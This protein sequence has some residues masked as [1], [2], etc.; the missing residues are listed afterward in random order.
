[1]RRLLLA[2]GLVALATAARAGGRVETAQ[3][4]VPFDGRPRAIQVRTPAASAD[5]ANL[6]VV[7]DGPQ[8]LD[9]IPL[10]AMLD[11]LEA[12]GRIPPTVAVLIDDGTGTVRIAD[13]GNRRAFADWVCDRLVPWVR[14]RYRVSSDPHRV[15]AYGSSAGGLAAAFIAFERPDVVGNALSQSG[16]FWRNAEAKGSPPWEWLTGAVAAAPR[17]DVRFVIDVGEKETTG[18]L[19]GTGPSI[20]AANRRLRDALAAKGY[21]VVYVEAKGGTHSPGSWAKRLPPALA[22]L[23]P[24]APRSAAARP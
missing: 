1:V 15:T 19:G 4:D 2:A 23:S 12:V 3:F 10:P 7:F 16:A 14:A 9:E 5:S 8:Y 24:R 21:D 17:K 22:A 20:L 18:V 13:L 11:S 6:L